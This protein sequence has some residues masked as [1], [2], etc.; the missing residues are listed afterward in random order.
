MLLTE[1]SISAQTV[2]L[3]NEWLALEHQ[4]DAGIASFAAVKIACRKS[5]GGYV[6]TV[7]GR[8]DVLPDTY[9]QSWPPPTSYP[10]TAKIASTDEATAAVMFDGT[11]HRERIKRDGI[12]YQ[13]YGQSFTASVTDHVYS[14][15]LVDVFSDACTALGLTLNSS[16]AR[17]TAPAVDYTAKGE[18]L[19]IDNLSDISAFFSHCFYIQS[20][21]LYLIDML[22]DNGSTIL[23]EFDIFPSVYNDPTPVTSVKATV[24]STEYSVAGSSGYGG[25]SA[26]VSISPVC[27][28]AQANIETALS[29]IKTII[30]RP[31]MQLIKPLSEPPAIGQRINITDESTWKP[32]NVWAR[33]RSI[34]WDFDQE[35]CVIEGEGGLS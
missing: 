18:K 9:D 21:T 25:S 6:E 11:A 34:T 20:G 29:D 2:R 12:E 22:A 28:T 14:G 30:E 3:S 15:S 32:L 33:V 7:F 4:W 13:L 35:Q 23:T 8:M 10:V 26:E 5:Y 19:I 27:H 16:A 1:H 24:L 17:S 31:S